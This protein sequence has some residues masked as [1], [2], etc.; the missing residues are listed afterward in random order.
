MVSLPSEA[1]IY[2]N[3]VRIKRELLPPGEFELRNIASYGGAGLVEIVI[4][5]PFGKEQRIKYPTY[6]TNLLLK[7]GIA[8]IWLSCRFFEK[9]FRH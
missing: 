3:G 7:K 5:D 1:D 6:S 2:L 8:R 9:R 4:R